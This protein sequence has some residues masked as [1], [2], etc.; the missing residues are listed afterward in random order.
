MANL[1]SLYEK[2]NDGVFEESYQ[3]LT[4]QIDTALAKEQIAWRQK[5]DVTWEL[6]VAT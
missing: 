4:S 5:M 3:R 1:Q 6:K 2:G